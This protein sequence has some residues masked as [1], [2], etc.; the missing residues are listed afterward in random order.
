MQRELDFMADNTDKSDA[1]AIGET[2]AL[3]PPKKKAA[4]E[5]AEAAPAAPKKKNAKKAKK[6]VAKK[7]A[8]KGRG[9]PRPYP[10]VPFNQATKI[11]EGIHKHASGEKIRLLTLLELL[12]L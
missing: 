3:K 12:E 2:D 9:P 4:K 6:A 1:P 8:R 5:S 10:V 11:G 7:D